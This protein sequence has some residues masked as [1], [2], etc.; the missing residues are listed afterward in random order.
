MNDTAGQG[1]STAKQC[2]LG[3]PGRV[4]ALSTVLAWVIL[5][6]AGVIISSLPYLAKVQSPPPGIRSSELFFAWITILLVYTPTN[7]ALLSMC[8]GLLGALGR[9]ATLHA[10]DEDKDYPE[11]IINPW[12][13]GMIRGFVTYLLVIAGLIAVV[14]TSPIAPP[15]QSQ[16]IRLAGFVSVTAFIAGYNPKTFSVFYSVI[17]KVFSKAD[18]AQSGGGNK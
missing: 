1:T 8:T 12:L 18:Q 6:A 3:V 13:S 14:D 7:I 2:G 17:S 9:C 10:S 11:D 15:T 4:I 5:F 16:Y